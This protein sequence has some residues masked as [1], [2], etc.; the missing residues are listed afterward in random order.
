[1]T[2]ICH[3]GNVNSNWCPM[4]SKEAHEALMEHGHIGKPCKDC[5]REIDDEE[6]R[7]LQLCSRCYALDEK[8]EAVYEPEVGQCLNC[9]REP[10]PLTG[11]LCKK[12]HLDAERDHD[13]AEGRDVLA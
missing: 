10:V 5:G 6:P 4:C 8:V 3:H 7:H 2:A 1:M 9:P 13:E 12:C 11:G